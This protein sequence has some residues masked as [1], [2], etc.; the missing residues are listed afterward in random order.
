MIRTIHRARFVVAEVDHVLANS[1][2][3]VAD[4][5]RISRIEPWTSPPAA[6]DTE[7]IDWGDAVI[8]PGL[9]NAHTHL[10]LTAL[11][12]Q[13][14][15]PRSFA[16]WLRQLIALRRA[17]TRDQF[18][19]SARAGARMLI[20][21][22]TTLAGDICAAGVSREALDCENL[23]KVIF[24]ETLG[25]D[26]ALREAR[27]SDIRARVEADRANPDGLLVAG[28]SAHAPYT[29]SEGLYQDCASLSEYLQIP[30]ATHVAETPEE[31]EFLRSGTG[32]LRELLQ[33]LGAV[34]PGWTPPG[35]APLAL[36]EKLGVL[37]TSPLLIHCNYVDE[38]ALTTILRTRSSVAYC[39]RSHAYFGHAPHPVRQMLDLGINVA[40]GTDSLASNSS[41]SMLD[42]LRYL[43]GVRKDLKAEEILRMATLNG[44][45]A[46]GFGGV[47]GRLRRGYWADMAV[48]RLPDN[49]SERNLLSQILEGAGDC[50][51]T[52][53]CG[54]IAW[55]RE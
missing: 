53:V 44:A 39:P 51:A 55:R 18:V 27:M 17:W 5:G 32:Q 49:I 14:A 52:V 22:G 11:H 36:L 50:L 21:S 29:V 38:N 20:A 37:N 30:L 48:L 2:V 45:S 4:P 24:E 28:V 35:E 10:E 43:F 54:Q 25:L 15:G 33:E 26:P 19:Q 46:L 6:L 7:Q 9:V 34:P 47:L 31:L 3:H 8:L 1:A 42:E 23:R 13:I 16:D 40:L 12:G 41:L